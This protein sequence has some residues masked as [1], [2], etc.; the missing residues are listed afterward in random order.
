MLDQRRGAR[1]DCV[2]I[3]IFG[4]CATIGPLETLNPYFKCLFWEGTFARLTNLWA[5]SMMN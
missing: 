3:A 5:Q 4:G 2:Y 1:G